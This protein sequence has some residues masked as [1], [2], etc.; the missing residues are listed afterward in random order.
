MTYII[1]IDGTI[2]TNTDGD[3]KKAVP[4]KERIDWVNK[5]YDLG[6]IIIFNT[7]RGWTTKLDWTAFTKKQLDDWGVKYHEV[8][9]RKPGGDVYIDDKAINSDL[10]FYSKGIA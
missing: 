7:S 8:F 6:H 5:M 10:F 3:Y 2:C 9:V 4:Y 1:D